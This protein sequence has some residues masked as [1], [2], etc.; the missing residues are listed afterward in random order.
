MLAIAQ[1]DAVLDTANEDETAT[2]LANL[3][4]A[5][6]A[7]DWSDNS[8][9]DPSDRT[10]VVESSGAWWAVYRGTEADEAHRCASADVARAID[11]VQP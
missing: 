7:W 9:H 1:V 11:A 6:G 3:L 10:A 2:A 4:D 8:D 5:K